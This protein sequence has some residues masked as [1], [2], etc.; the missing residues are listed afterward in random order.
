M[1]HELL[2]EQCRVGFPLVSLLNSAVEPAA[3]PIRTSTTSLSCYTLCSC[4]CYALLVDEYIFCKSSY[5]SIL[6]FTTSQYRWS[7]R[8]ETCVALLFF[9]L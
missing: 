9:A 1:A 6:T 7:S 2:V 5:D 4:L 3:A 8:T